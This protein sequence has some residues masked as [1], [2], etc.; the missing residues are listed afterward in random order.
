MTYTCEN[1]LAAFEI[2]PIA[3]QIIEGHRFLVCG[4]GKNMIYDGEM[5]RQYAF[6]RECGVVESQTSAEARDQS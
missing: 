1:C 6:C 3:D 2:I 4:T 5:N